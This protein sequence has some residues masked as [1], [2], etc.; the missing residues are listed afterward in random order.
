VSGQWGARQFFWPSRPM[1]APHSQCL[2]S[3]HRRMSVL[4]KG[5]LNKVS[6]WSN[7]TT[8]DLIASIAMWSLSCLAFQSFTSAFYSR[9]SETANN[10]IREELELELR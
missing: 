6:P 8:V 2:P 3:P 10:W 4:N 9:E 1:G 7:A 5:P